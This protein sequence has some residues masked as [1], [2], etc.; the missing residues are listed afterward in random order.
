MKDNCIVCAEE[1][2]LEKG[3]HRLTCSE[4]CKKKYAEFREKLAEVSPE[5]RD[6]LIHPFFAKIEAKLGQL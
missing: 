4:K 1:F 2:E 5:E 6:G 3:T